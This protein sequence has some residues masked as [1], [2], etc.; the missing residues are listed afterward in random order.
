MKNTPICAPMN[1]KLAEA[2]PSAKVT[3]DARML[4]SRRKVFFK[5]RRR[6]KRAWTG[7]VAGQRC[8]RGRLVVL[9]DGQLATLMQAQRGWTYVRT[10][11]VAPDGHF[12]HDY[13]PATSLRLYK[14][15]AAVRLGRRKGWKTEKKSQAKAATC[16]I[17]GSCPPRP[18]SRRRGRPRRNGMEHG[19][20]TAPQA[21]TPGER[22]S[23]LAEIMA[24]TESCDTGC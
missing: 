7:F 2:D 4:G 10:N 16:K 1:I 13:L 24:S 15:P 12:I 22:R 9:P 11:Q 17:N 18:G 23:A 19:L 21:G 6:V 14:L 20:V 3:R 8:W 5:G